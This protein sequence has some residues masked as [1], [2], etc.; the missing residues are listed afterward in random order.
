M[1]A[2]TLVSAVIF[3]VC[4]FGAWTVCAAPPSATDPA[5]ERNFSAETLAKIIPGVTTETE[6]QALLGKPSYAVDFGSGALCPPKPSGKSINEPTVNSWNYRGRDSDG[7]Y[8]VH[9][10]FDANYVTYLISKIPI[11]GVGVAR[12][13]KPQATVDKPSE[14]ASGKL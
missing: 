8:V 2:R 10:E 4:W 11:T 6:V 12:V 9:I 3:G 5:T 1:A 14:S 13:A 7:P